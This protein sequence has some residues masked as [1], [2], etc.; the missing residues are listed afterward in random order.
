MIEMKLNTI[1]DVLQQ[2]EQIYDATEGDLRAWLHKEVLLNALKFK[3]DDLETLDL[4]II[5]QKRIPA[6][7]LPLSSA[8]ILFC[9]IVGDHLLT[10][11]ISSKPLAG[12]LLSDFRICYIVYGEGSMPLPSCPAVVKPFRG[13]ASLI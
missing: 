13:R 4:K 7:V 1:Q 5:I 12:P 6:G 11:L 3:R 10:V 2:V 9:M 8:G